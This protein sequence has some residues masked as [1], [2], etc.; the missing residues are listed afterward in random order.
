VTSESRTL[1]LDGFRGLACLLVLLLHFVYALVPP[2]VPNAPV[3]YL[4]RGMQFGWIGVDLFFVLSGFLLGGIVIDQR[5]ADNFFRVFYARRAFRIFPLYLAW[6]ASFWILRGAA[7]WPPGL[8][9]DNRPAW[10]YLLYAQNFFDAALDQWGARWMTITWSLAIEEQF[11]LVLPALIYVC[12]GRR[13]PAILGLLI[14]SAPLLRYAISLYF[15]DRQLATYTLLPC[16][17]DALFIGV[18]AADVIRRPGVVDWLRDNRGLLRG[19]LLMLGTMVAL[20]VHR[21]PWPMLPVMREAGYTW[22]A[23]FAVVLLIAALYDPVIA[24]AFRFA[25]LRYLGM[26]S[27]GVY[28]IHP[29]ALGLTH[30]VLL[31]GA[32]VMN[33]WETVG[34]TA[35]AGSLT[36][37]VAILSYRLVEAPLIA[38]GRRWRYTSR[39]GVGGQPDAADHTARCGVG[40]TA[41]EPRRLPVR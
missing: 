23:L 9:D 36:L 10:A 40:S 21:A 29:A 25:P 38:V 7:D 1:E 32:P 34:V 30:W 15:P 11:Y 35:L 39:N 2:D 33:S 28:V 14:L 16:R 19:A 17:W 18:L 27:Y 37:G 8:F 5:R 20:F 24:P 12:S 41:P 6:L 31:G 22:V 4:A 3:R 26:I 13:R